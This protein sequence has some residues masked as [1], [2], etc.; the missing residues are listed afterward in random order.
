LGLEP[1]RPATAPVNGAPALPGP[2]VPDAAA[3]APPAHVLGAHHGAGHASHTTVIARPATGVSPAPAATIAGAAWHGLNSAPPRRL[4]HDRSEDRSGPV[5]SAD[6]R[7]PARY[8][9]LSSPWTGPAP[10][11]GHADLLRA[12]ARPAGAMTPRTS[13]ARDT[14]HGSL[15]Q[16]STPFGPPG[17]GVMGGS[18]GGAAGAATA[19]VVCA[20]LTGFLLLLA[21]P[22]LGRR[23][24]LPTAAV[25]AGFASLQ[26]RPG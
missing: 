5:P 1:D 4:G 8:A 17:R 2:K 7:S 26:L 22:P 21:Y 12:A 15:P 11:T 23:R 25:P 18:S 3:S 6:P 13:R 24:L 19:S 9:G 10:G 14:G 16:P 20:M